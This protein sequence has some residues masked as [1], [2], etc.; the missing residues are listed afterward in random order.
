ML[1][2]LQ[3]RFFRDEHELNTGTWSFEA[4][5]EDGIR[6]LPVEEALKKAGAVLPLKPAR[7][8][9]ER[10]GIEVIRSDAAELYGYPIIK[11]ERI[12]ITAMSHTLFIIDRLKAERPVRVV[13]SFMLNDDDNRMKVKAA[14]ETKLVLRRNAAG[15]K[16]FQ[17]SAASGGEA[18]R[19]SLWIGDTPY[20][21][22]V[23]MNAST[24]RFTGD[25]CQTE[26]IHVYAAARDDT[27]AVKEWHI[28][29]LTD[30]QFYVEP[31]AG[32]TGYSLE[33]GEND[34]LVVRS[35][36]DGNVRTICYSSH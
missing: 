8:V 30:R 21:G 7:M 36:P 23:E 3:E 16:F 19:S 28:L 27:E 35:H 2:H 15:M 31:P 20:S 12:W 17:V 34:E 26:H 5:D 25:S 22:P 9:T 18:S 11:A 4:A 32:L 10:D 29:P 13:S 1:P 33:L 24:F 6:Q 14:A